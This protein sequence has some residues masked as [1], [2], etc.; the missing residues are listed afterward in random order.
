MRS[1]ARP[2]TLFHV[3]PDL[4]PERT[5]LILFFPAFISFLGKKNPRHDGAGDDS[6]KKRERERG[7]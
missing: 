5:L 3:G 2:N 7:F 1:K 4:G 6:K